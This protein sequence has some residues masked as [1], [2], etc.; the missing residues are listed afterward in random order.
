MLAIN[1]HN[2]A[3]G[4]GGGRSGS[5]SAGH[6]RSASASGLGSRRSGEITIQEEDEDENNENEVAILED[7]DADDVEEVDQFSPIIRIPG[8]K[9]EEFYEG[10]E[11]EKSSAGDVRGG[12]SEMTTV[13]AVISR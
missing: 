1:T 8:E 7:D 10:G 9:V 5:S 4:A 13:T 3:S 12:G 2:Q 6:S 11:G